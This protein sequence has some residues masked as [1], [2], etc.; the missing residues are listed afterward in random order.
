[1]S[2]FDA[3]YRNKNENFYENI[4]GNY[5]QIRVFESGITTGVYFDQ[6]L[7][8]INLRLDINGGISTLSNFNIEFDRKEKESN[9]KQK[10]IY[11]VGYSPSFFFFP[12]LTAQ[13]DVLH[14]KYNTFGIQAKANWMYLS[15]SINYTQTT[16]TWTYENK[17]KE[18]IINPAHSFT[19]LEID[20]GIFLRW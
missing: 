19:K 2:D 16:F 15:R 20:L 12:E 3:W 8:F 7:G 17:M 13:F 1:M 6:S 4:P 9:F 10:I 5:A 14:L 11:D 18:E